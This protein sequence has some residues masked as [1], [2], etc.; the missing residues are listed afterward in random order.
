MGTARTRRDRWV[1]EGLAL[2]VDGG[3]DA[4]RV[5][6][7]AKRIGVTKGGFYGYFS[8]RQ[9]L[10]EAMLD[11]WRKDSIDDVLAAVEEAGGEPT[12]QAVLAGR[13]T[14]GD[15]ILPVDMAVREWARRDPNVAE[16]L[17]DVDNRRMDLLRSALAGRCADDE[18][19]EARCL[20]AFCVAIGSRLLHA[21]HHG[22]T[23]EQVLETVTRMIV[24]P[25]ST[26]PADP[27]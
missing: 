12:S 6:V 26:V 20:M 3:P 24:D 9:A 1:D 25:V 23:R 11:R 15:K 16:R 7:L 10:L 17:R 21:D 18:E 2:L 13:L 5:E 27:S 4:V 19:L 14:F 8:D 22:R